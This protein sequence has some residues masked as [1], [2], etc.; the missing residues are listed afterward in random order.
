MLAVSIT[1]PLLN[2]CNS[3]M[4]LSLFKKKKKIVPRSVGSP[5]TSKVP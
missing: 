2:I 5:G 4:S 1:T 3:K